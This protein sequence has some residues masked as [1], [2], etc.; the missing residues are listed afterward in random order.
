MLTELYSKELYL[1]DSSKV[2]HI[3]WLDAMFA[4][5]LIAI[6]LSHIGSFS[7]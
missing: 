7:F 4:N 3:L 1:R 2:M 5:N 6:G